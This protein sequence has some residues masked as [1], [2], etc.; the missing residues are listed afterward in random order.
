MRL[1]DLTKRPV[2]QRPL[3]YT[4]S[5]QAKL[6]QELAQKPAPK[7]TAVEWAI[8]EGGGSL[9][10]LRTKK[11]KEPRVGDDTP[12]DWNPG[13]QDLNW[14]KKNAL[15]DGNRLAQ[16]GYQLFIPRANLS[17]QTARDRRMKNLANP[18]AYD[19]K[20]NLTP[21][22]D[23]WEQGPKELS[24]TGQTNEAAPTIN[25]GAKNNVPPGG[26][27]PVAQLWTSTAIKQ[28]DGTWTSDWGQWIARN[29]RDWL[30]PKGYL[31]KVK[32]GALVLELN[33]YDAERLQQAFADLGRSEPM[34]DRYT[35]AHFPWQEINKHFDA[36]RVVHP[37]RDFTYGWDVESTAWFDT[38]HLTLVGEVP[39]SQYGVDDEDI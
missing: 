9:E 33:D 5:L 26:N 8:M 29:H 34:K 30:A 39:I 22:Y 28:K 36:V 2:K 11:I 12:H 13:W 25:P 17:A 21:Q 20:G 19:E 10:E 14:F 37:G 23:R 6:E 7:F 3:T 4:E 1:N 24:P 32:P 38:S 27:K 18:Y 31:Y 35:T 15:E 16:R